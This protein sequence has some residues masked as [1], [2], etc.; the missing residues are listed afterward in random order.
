LI[1]ILDSLLSGDM[2]KIISSILASVVI[3]FTAL[4][5]HEFAHGWAAYKLGDPT[6]KN[7]GRLDLN[8]F[9]HFDIIG[10]TAL[11]L[12]GFGWAKPVPV[13]PYY[14]KNRK[15][16]MALTAL[17]GPVS[18]IIVA[19]IALAIKKIIYYAVIP[20]G[21]VPA[22]FTILL[23]VIQYIIEIN[24]ML[25]AFNLIPI[26]PLDGSKIIAFFMPMH[27]YGRVENWFARYQ[28]YIFYGMIAILFILP[29]AG[30]PFGMISSIIY[31]P[32][33]FIKTGIYY[34]MNFVT[35]FIDVIAKLL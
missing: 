6:A 25:A 16:G 31:I 5:I 4:P 34:V 22:F 19:T 13:N 33:N 20:M 12:F 9:S 8:P 24:V 21:E 1:E 14:F 29:R 26:P 32:L 17:A 2:I 28:Q 15:N 7:Q 3:V 18:N 23:Y 35:G 11:L 30:G 27:V 10:T